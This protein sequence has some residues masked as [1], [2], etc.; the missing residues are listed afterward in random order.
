M[1]QDSETGSVAEQIGA[2]M[3]RARRSPDPH[4]TYEEIGRIMG[5][6]RG[7]VARWE[8][9]HTECSPSQLAAWAD[10]VKLD[11]AGRGAI[12]ALVMSEGGEEVAD[13]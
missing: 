2:I 9:G 8:A 3:R 11:A 7:T 12:R 5:V 6:T 10:A 1:A 4:I 13:G